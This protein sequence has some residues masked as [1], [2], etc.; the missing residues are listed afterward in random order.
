MFWERGRG[1][2]SRLPIFKRL[3]PSLLSV[4]K[5]DRPELIRELRDDL[6]DVIAGARSSGRMAELLDHAEEALRELGGVNMQETHDTI[7]H[8]RAL[9]HLG[10]LDD[11]LKQTRLAPRQVRRIRRVSTEFWRRSEAERKSQGL[12]ERRL[13]VVSGLDPSTLCQA[14]QRNSEPSR[15]AWSRWRAD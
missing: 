9:V 1:F 10:R 5:A 13:A 8:A 3:A 6:D 2:K 7:R 15:R 12:S 14:R 11:A 4:S